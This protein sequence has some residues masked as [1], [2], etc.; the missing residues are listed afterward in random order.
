M[1]HQKLILTKIL[2]KT[3]IFEGTASEAV[4]LFPKNVNVS[5]LLSLAGIGS[6]ETMVRVV[7]DPNTDKNTHQIESKGKFGKIITTV[8]NAYQILIILKQV[9]LPYCQQLRHFVQFV[10]ITLR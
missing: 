7:A 9:D 10:L 3:I 5:A 4:R 1:K 2:E 8:E 6:H